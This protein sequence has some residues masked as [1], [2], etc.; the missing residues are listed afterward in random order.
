MRNDTFRSLT[1]IYGAKINDL[2]FAGNSVDTGRRKKDRTG[3][4]TDPNR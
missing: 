4:M 1:L 2:L 3:C